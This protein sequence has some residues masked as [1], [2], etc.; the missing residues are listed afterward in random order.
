MVIQLLIS[1]GKEI[2][3]KF[4]GAVEAFSRRNPTSPSPR[5]DHSKRRSFEEVAVH[6][7]VVNISK[8]QDFIIHHTKISLLFSKPIVKMLHAIIC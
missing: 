3:E 4:S 5:G 2:R 7:D 8:Q 6:K 1:V